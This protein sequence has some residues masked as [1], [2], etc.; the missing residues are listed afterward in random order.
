M[1]PTGLPVLVLFRQCPIWPENNR[2]RKCVRIKVWSEIVC[3]DLQLKS[4]LS[5]VVS[6][7]KYSD[8]H[9]LQLKTL[10]LCI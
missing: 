5:A 9:R 2:H 1:V 7:V 8:G 6:G 10:P 3:R 4:S